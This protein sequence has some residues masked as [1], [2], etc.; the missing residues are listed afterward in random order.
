MATYVRVLG[1][2]SDTIRE[3]MAIRIRS[4]AEP[5]ESA[6]PEATREALGAILLGASVIGARFDTS[7]KEPEGFNLRSRGAIGP[8]SLASRK[9]NATQPS[10][11]IARKETIRRPASTA[12]TK[13]KGK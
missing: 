5:F 4:A 12:P 2:R 13:K 11:S 1:L 10:G 7:T 8:T 6:D 3:E 9:Q